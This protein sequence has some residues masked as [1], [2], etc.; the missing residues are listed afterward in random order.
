[1]TAFGLLYLK[2]AVCPIKQRDN[3]GC[4]ITCLGV[5]AGQQLR[6]RFRTAP[7]VDSKGSTLHI[8]TCPYL[9]IFIFSQLTR[10]MYAHFQA[11]RFGLAGP[12]GGATPDLGRSRAIP[13]GGGAPLPGY[14]EWRQTTSTSTS[15]S[16]DCPVPVLV[17]VLVVYCIGGSTALVHQ[18]STVRV[19]YEYS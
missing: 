13:R 12:P 8:G 2:C 3:S 5:N 10:P 15:T 18:C 6:A 19:R 9:N 4:R 14:T 11:Y 17:L 7:S 16:S 1:M